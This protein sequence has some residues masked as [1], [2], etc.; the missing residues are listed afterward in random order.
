MQ[1]R[2]ATGFT[3][4]VS[5]ITCWYVI[6][7]AHVRELYMGFWIKVSNPWQGHPSGVN[8]I[9]FVTS[10]GTQ[11]Y[12]LMPVLHGSAAPYYLDQQIA[13]TNAPENPAYGGWLS[14]N[15]ANPPFTLGVWHRVEMYLKY[16]TTSTSYNGIMKQWLDGTLVMSYSDINYADDGIDGWKIDPTWGGIGGSKT[17]TDYIWIDHVHTSAR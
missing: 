9:G 16:G 8:K 15:V 6:P 12:A 7:G 1:I 17:E 13:E 4:G 3:G 10:G 5:P 11:N 2:F 14:Q